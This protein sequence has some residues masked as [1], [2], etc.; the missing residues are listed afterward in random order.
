MGARWSTEQVQ[1][2]A[3][4][5]ASFRAARKLAAPRPWS[6]AGCDDAAVW[7]DCQGSGSRPYQVMVDLGGP[8]YRCSC[9]S[10]KFPCKHAL[11]LLLRWVDGSLTQGARPDAVEEWLASRRERSARAEERA[12]Q[13]TQRGGELA[14]PAAAQRRVEQRLAR[15]AAG[16]AEFERWLLDQVRDGLAGAAR[17]GYAHWD[18]LAARLVDAQAPGAAGMVRGMGVLPTTGPEW[19]GRLLESY[20]RAWLLC[21]GYARVEELEPAVAATLRTRVGFRT[22]REDV[23]ANGEQVRDRWLVLGSRDEIDIE[24][25]STRR[26]WLRGSQSGRRALVL[27]FAVAGQSLDATL[28][29]GTD[30]DAALAFFPAVVPLR[31]L[32]AETFGVQ[33]VGEPRFERFD[34]VLETY[35]RALAGDPWLGEWPVAVGPVTP[36]FDRGWHVVDDRSEALPLVGGEHWRLAAV[37]GGRRVVVAG[38]WSAAGLRPLTVWTADRMVRL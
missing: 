17:A 30:V 23:L 1:G 37:S 4:D 11:A 19:P 13:R 22:P 35:A 21:R 6:S 15:V 33:P 18:G 24:G 31:A 2:V 36:A 20:A 26:V 29:P 8:A 27:S 25:L 5:E 7:G 38:E 14:D 28:V 3:P 9:P 32:V 10:R 12:E 34:E 16:M